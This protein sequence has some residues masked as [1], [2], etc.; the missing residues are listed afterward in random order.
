MSAISD[1]EV[2]EAEPGS[3]KLI[4]TLGFAG[5][6]SGL[7]LVSV[8]L[9]TKPIIENN[10]AEALKAAVFKVLP[11]TVRFETL[12]IID[13]KLQTADPVDK[14][15]EKIFLGRDAD[16][17]STGFALSDGE[18]GFQDIIGVIYG[19]NPVNHEIIG[20]EVLSCKE[21][22]GLG[23][24]IFKDISFV[25]GFLGLSVVPEIVAV[26]KGEKVKANEVEAITG[27]TISSK[28]VVR[29][30]NKSVQKWKEPMEKYMEVNHQQSEAAP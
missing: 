29:L 1:T 26:K 19:Y 6:I 5:F 20:Y 17:K 30:L 15:A 11:G 27:A 16:G 23:D 14:D 28:A 9:F 25:S 18:V 10:K 3:A 7:V 12:T 8:F 13:G 21:T 24:K 2:H 22:P 4:F